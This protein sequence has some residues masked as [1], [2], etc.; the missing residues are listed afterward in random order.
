MNE[1][2]QILS[3]IDKDDD[4]RLFNQDTAEKNKNDEIVRLIDSLAEPPGAD[5]GDR[6]SEPAP[7]QEEAHEPEPL[8]TGAGEPVPEVE[9]L[10]TFTL[11][12]TKPWNRREP[13]L[14]RINPDVQKSDRESLGKSFYFVEDATNPDELKLI[15]KQEIVAFLRRP[16][17]HITARYEDFIYKII[18]SSV[19]GVSK[20]FKLDP[21]TEKLFIYHTGPLTFYKYIREMFSNKKYGYCYKY[22]PGNKASRFFPEEFIKEIVMK[23]FEENINTLDLQFDSIQ[24]YEE[25]KKIVS[26]RYYR[27]L[28]VFN[29]RLEQLNE[30]LGLDRSIS[31]AKLFQLKGGEWFGPLNLE[32]YRRFLG[33]V[34][35]M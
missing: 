21:A 35:F 11:K 17:D 14:I 2:D 15:I 18:I 10:G 1:I 28:R 12:G 32:I 19:G 13:Y 6:K 27:D 23:W 30:K 5:E 29:G 26:S 7:L 20:N 8:E 24:K 3:N 33:G 16:S 34:I 4:E 31:R 25:I 22:L 9:N